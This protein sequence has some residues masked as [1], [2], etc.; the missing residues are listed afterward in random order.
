MYL[1]RLAS[2]EIFSPSNKKHR[3]VGR[4]KDLLEL[5]HTAWRWERAKADSNVP[6]KRFSSTQDW[7]FSW[8]YWRRFKP[9][10]KWLCVNG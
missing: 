2:K 5:R 9:D 8:R 6:R 7:R 4:A 1:T 10:G 3:A